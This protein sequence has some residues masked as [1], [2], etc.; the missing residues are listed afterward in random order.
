MEK[1]EVNRRVVTQL[2][3]DY[4]VYE[5][6]IQYEPLTEEEIKDLGIEEFFK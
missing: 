4:D 6:C 1:E 3:G 5:W 2:D